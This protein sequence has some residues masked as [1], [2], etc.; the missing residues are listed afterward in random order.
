M[1][2]HGEVAGELQPLFSESHT[3]TLLVLQQLAGLAKQADAAL[4]AFAETLLHFVKN[5]DEIRRDTSYA[6]LKTRILDAVKTK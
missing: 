2:E 4:H 1:A 6:Q 5:Q 3:E